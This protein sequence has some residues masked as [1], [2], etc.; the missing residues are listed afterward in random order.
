MTAFSMQVGCCCGLTAPI[1]MNQLALWDGLDNPN[2]FVLGRRY[3]WQC[4]RCNNQICV[5]LSLLE[6]N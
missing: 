2:G 6:D 1:G 4:P 5:N 3:V